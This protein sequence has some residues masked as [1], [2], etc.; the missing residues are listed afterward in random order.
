[1]T[2]KEKLRL[3]KLLRSL[4]VERAERERKYPLGATPANP[5]YC[6]LV[7]RINYLERVSL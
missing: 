5:S 2:F 4:K 3:K 1:M 6:A 7:E